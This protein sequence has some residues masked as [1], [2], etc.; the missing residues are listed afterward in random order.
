[1]ITSLVFDL[2]RKS[3]TSACCCNS[4]VSALWPSVL[5]SGCEKVAGKVADLIRIS[6]E[7]LFG[8][9]HVSRGMHRSC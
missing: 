7:G 3:C 5:L 9:V 4:P 8:F 6:A 2:P 1:M